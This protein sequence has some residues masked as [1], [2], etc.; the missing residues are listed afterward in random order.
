MKKF[1]VST[2]NVTEECFGNKC[3]SQNIPRSKVRLEVL[4]STRN[5]LMKSCVQKRMS[6]RILKLFWSASTHLKLVKLHCSKS[7]AC[8]TVSVSRPKMAQSSMSTAPRPA[9]PSLIT[10]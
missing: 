9:S 8:V 2:R 7:A 4:N 3:Y 6:I 5:F 1:H 10:K